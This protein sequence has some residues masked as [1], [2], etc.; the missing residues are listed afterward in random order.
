M[1]L[2]SSLHATPATASTPEGQSSSRGALDTIVTA[3]E[4]HGVVTSHSVGDDGREPEQWRRFQRLRNQA[5]AERMIELTKHRSPVVRCYAFRGLAIANHPGLFTVLQR[6]VCDTAIVRTFMGSDVSEER[7][8]DYALGAVSP[9]HFDFARGYRLSKDEHRVVDSLLLHRPGLRLRARRWMLDVLE[10][11]P[12]EH[13]RLRDLVLVEKEFAAL[14]ALLRLR[15]DTDVELV[16]QALGSRSLDL[17]LAGLRAVEAFPA[18]TLYP[19]LVQMFVEM[20]RDRKEV[21]PEFRRLCIA[22][23]AYPR[24]P[25]VALFTTAIEDRTSPRWAYAASAIKLG[26]TLHRHEDYD[27]L[28]EEIEL[29]DAD[30]HFFGIDLAGEREPGPTRP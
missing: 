5:S 11:R 4:H 15:R 20:R 25:T 2:A 14:P 29:A 16:H 17:L 19:P 9:R 21:M 12:E 6:A 24:A 8:G 22:L 27:G 28:L 10:P 30:R 7:V 18:D 3:M 13:A 23:A 1:I 26:L